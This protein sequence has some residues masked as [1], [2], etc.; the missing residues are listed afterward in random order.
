MEYSKKLIKEAKEL[1]PD[2]GQLYRL[3]SEGSRMVGGFF[4]DGCGEISYNDILC[5]KNFDELK[6]HARF[7]KRRH[8]L[9][10]LWVSEINKY[11]KNS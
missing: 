2:F 10:Q 5:C 9:Y 4:A 1:Y 11:E 6:G 3:L 8:D 7:I